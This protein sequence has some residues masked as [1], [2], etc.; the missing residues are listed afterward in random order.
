[1]T[2]KVY[3]LLYRPRKIDQEIARVNAKISA[4][5]RSLEASGTRADTERVQTSPQDRMSL[6]MA[7]IDELE[8][9]KEDLV[10]DRIEAIRMIERALDCLG[11]DGER[12]V[13][14]MQY[15]GRARLED[16]ADKVG[17]SNRQTYRIRKAALNHL[18][19]L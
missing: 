1:M 19:S 2:D 18:D 5:R 12:T 15:V 6:V 17:Y 13:L 8:R 7:E 3:G 16:I 9:K 14:Y 11:D 4:L 10:W